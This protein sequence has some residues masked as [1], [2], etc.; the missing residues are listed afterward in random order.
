VCQS[1]GGC[2]G[3]GTY[4]GRDAEESASVP[5]VSVVG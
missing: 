4:T 2:A 5:I 3:D 1:A